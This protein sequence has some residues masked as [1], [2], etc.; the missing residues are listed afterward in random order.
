MFVLRWFVLSVSVI[1]SAGCAS[2]RPVMVSNPIYVPV[3]DQET[4]WERTVDVVHNFQFP[5]KREDKLDGIIE[6]DYKVGAGLL[7][8][9][10]KDS[11]G[12]TSRLESSLQSIRRRV[13]LNVMPAE[14]G[15]LVG[16]EVFKELED[17]KGLAGNAG[18]AATFQTSSDLSRNLNLVVGETAPSGWLPQGRDAALEQVILRR[19]QGQF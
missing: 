16:V 8:P 4:V 2:S 18:G 6:T 5:I 17:V 11:R 7:E 9:W 19:L 10:H 13:F 3:R 12:F 14:G 1:M 15:Y